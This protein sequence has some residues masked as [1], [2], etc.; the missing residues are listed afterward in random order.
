M[1]IGSLTFGQIITCEFCETLL[2]SYFIPVHAKIIGWVRFVAGVLLTTLAFPALALSSS[3]LYFESVDTPS[4]KI[5]SIA[6]FI[7]DRQGFIWIGTGNGLLRY[8]GYEFVYYQGRPD[9]PGSLSGNSILSLFEDYHGTIWAS[10]ENGLNRFDR[11]TNKFTSYPFEPSANAS[12]YVKQII[13]DGKEGLWLATRRG[14]Q[15]FDPDSGR[16][17]RYKHDPSKPDSIASDNISS[18]A[19]DDKEGLWIATWPGGVDY[20]APGSS[21]FVHYRVDS[22]AQPVPL[23]N[24]IRYLRF[25]HQQRLWMGSEAGLFVWQTSSDWSQRKRLDVQSR[26]SGIY[27]DQNSTI[28]VATSSQGLLRWDNDKNQFISYQHRTE[29]PYSL[30][31]NVIDAVFV[32]RSNI[33]WAGIDSNGTLARADLNIHGAEYYIPRDLAPDSSNVDNGIQCLA[34]DT[35]GRVWLGE[36]SGLLLLDTAARKVIKTYHADPKRPGPLSAD[37]IY[38]LY[39]PRDGPLWVGTPSGLNRLDSKDGRFQTIHLGDAASD[40]IS[41]IAPGR[42]GNLWLSTGG[43]LIRYDPQSGAIKQFKHDPANPDSRSINSSTISLEDRAGRI[44]VGGGNY[45]GGLDVLDQRTEKFQHYFH[46]PKNP[47]SLNDDHI[48]SIFDDGQ[49]SLWIGTDNGLNRVISNPDGTFSFRA[50]PESV[51]TNNR[52]YVIAGDSAGKLWLS[53]QAGLLKFDPA[54]GATINFS[55]LSGIFKSYNSSSFYRDAEGLMYFGSSKGVMVVDPKTFSINSFP[56]HAA[57]TDIKIFNHSLRE[58]IRPEGVDLAGAV[59]EPN[60]LTLPWQQSVFSLE[61]SSLHY[62]T[63]RLN[64]YAY[65]LDGFDKDWIQ[66]DADHRHATYTNLNPGSYVFHV[67]ASNNRDTWSETSLPITITPPF[68]ATWLFKALVAMVLL[69]L[70]TML[71][72]WRIRQLNRNEIRLE[73]LVAE[74]SRRLEKSLSLLQATLESTNDAILVVDLH[75]IWV[76]YNQRFIDLWQITDEIIAAKNDQAALSYVLNQLEDAEAFLEK[77]RELYATPETDSFD[78][79][80]F[81]DGKIIERYSIPQVIDGKVVGRVW[82]FRDATERKQAE[83]ALGESMR[84]LEEKERSKTRFLAAAGHDLRQPLAAANLFIDALKFTSPSPG[85]NE[86]IE[87]LDQA[88]GNFNGLLDALLDVSKLDAGMIKPEYTSIAVADIFNWVEQGFAS[89]ANEKHLRLKLVFP[90][91]ER[92]VVHSDLGLLKSVLMNLVSNAIKYTLHGTIL[93]CARRRGG[94]ML[95]QVW[96]TG[97]GIKAEHLEPIFG[98]FYQVNNPQRDKV[99]GIGLGLSL[100]KRSISLLGGEV[101]CRSQIG[102][103]S[104]F[105]FRLPLDSVQS[106]VVPQSDTEVMPE[107]IAQAVFVRGKSIVVVEDDMLVAE[108][109]KKSLE[110]MGGKVK[111]FSSAEDA[112]RYDLIEHADYYI[113]DYMLGGAFNGIQYLNQLRQKLGKPII[114]VLMTGDT[115]PSFIREAENCDWPVLHKPV[116]I[117]RLITSLSVQAQ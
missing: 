112:L 34:G 87:R 73:K 56:S 35:N 47:A 43:G 105:E 46:D 49:G 17:V 38:S 21:T 60:S 28:W 62:A 45:G 25:D 92:L 79:I 64:R 99:S 114:A 8:D 86:I 80:K 39:Q 55:S 30:P 7:Q 29:N 16:F 81:K 18:V 116:N 110:T 15:H 72:R 13:G 89:L 101:S 36:T 41:H 42:E 10:T 33:L 24:N 106:E 96:D 57:I 65:R 59:T 67:K 111:C 6:S 97:I 12:Q 108:A 100:V 69:S 40:F 53:T 26:V 61:F 75:G 54:T 58:G 19:L 51:L 82:S 83:Y 103:G 76:A 9:V 11:E 77:V 68:W 20:L 63:P 115:S 95:F 113:S 66:V 52:I 117:S 23:I 27:E 32:D 70:A 78:I 48:W 88:M 5:S 4:G 104:V 109:L 85:Q 14:L 2:S 44:W 91:K 71:Y 31:G 22:A 90:R 74:R 93:V 98:E 102:R 107:R 1:V 3:T 94:D 84:Q 37:H 50:Y